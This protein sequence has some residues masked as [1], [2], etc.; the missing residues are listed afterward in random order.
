MYTERVSF[1]R[2]RVT[3]R[4]RPNAAGLP[5]ALRALRFGAAPGV[6]IEPPGSTDVPV[7]AMVPLAPA[8]WQ[9]AFHVRH[10]PDGPL[11]LPLTL[12][13]DCGEWTTTLAASGTL[14]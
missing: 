10:T 14:R 2:L 6:L 3:V 7:P 12:V 5:N 4:A 8:T 11:A 1:G 9:V 13:D